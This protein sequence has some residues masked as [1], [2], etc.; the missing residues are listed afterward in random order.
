V[1]AKTTGT[2][3]FWEMTGA[4]PL[5]G[6]LRLALEQERG[7]SFADASGLQVISEAGVLADHSVTYFRVFDSAAAA[8]SG[9]EVRYFGDLAAE[10]VLHSGHVAEDDSVVL[11][12]RP[13]VSQ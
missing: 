7:V 11:D 10:L 3:K 2:R 13:T 8:E 12:V 6:K 9:V 5:S 1:R 4:T